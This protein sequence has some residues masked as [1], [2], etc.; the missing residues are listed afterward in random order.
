MKSSKVGRV[1]LAVWTAAYLVVGGTAKTAGAASPEVIREVQQV[2]LQ[3]DGRVHGMLV[4]QAGR[5]VSDAPVVIGEEGKLLK[6]LRTDAEGKFVW[7]EARVGAFQVVTPE[8]ATVYRVWPS[9]NA[10]KDAKPAIIQTVDPTIARGASHGPL[11]TFLTNPIFL[12]LLVAAAI[13]I[14]LAL[15]DD[16]DSAS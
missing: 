6:Q 9:D 13:A 5:G 8:R 3:P 15:D 4:D 11:V 2:V 12:A 10:P 14:P 7:K 1:A 16:D